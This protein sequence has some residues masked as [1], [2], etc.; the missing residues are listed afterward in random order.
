MTDTPAAIRDRYHRMLM[1]RSGVE[2][3]HMASSMFASARALAIASL[4]SVTADQ[5]PGELA[6]QL[7]LRTYAGDFD[8]PTTARIVSHLRSVYPTARA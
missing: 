3:L 2:R 1:A 4:R 5:P 6:A 8:A 7:F